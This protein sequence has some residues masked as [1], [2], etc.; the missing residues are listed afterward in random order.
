[1][2]LLNKDIPPNMMVVS[3]KSL[4]NIKNRAY[5]IRWTVETP[6]GTKTYETPWVRWKECFVLLWNITILSKCKSLITTILLSSV[7]PLLWCLI[8][9]KRWKCRIEIR[10]IQQLKPNR[11]T[12]KFCS[13]KCKCGWFERNIDSPILIK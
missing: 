3:F 12:S 10:W 6:D 8:I 1:M 11:S 13:K 5:W 7:I 4:H 9:S 2:S